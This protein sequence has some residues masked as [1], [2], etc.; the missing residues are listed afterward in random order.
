MGRGLSTGFSLGEEKRKENPP[1]SVA[2]E[3]EMGLFVQIVLLPGVFPYKT[4]FRR[5]ALP[6][7]GRRKMGIIIAEERG[8]KR[9]PPH[10]IM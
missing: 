5:A 10:A 7:T 6:L 4:P 8:R 9:L 2:S 3:R 1:V